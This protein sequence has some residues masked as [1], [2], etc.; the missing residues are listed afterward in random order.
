[1][2]KSEDF[3]YIVDYTHET[4]YDCESYGCDSICR[5]GQIENAHVVFV[6]VINITNHL[7]ELYFNNSKSSKRDRIINNVLG[8]ITDDINYYTIDRTLRINR[9]YDPDNWDINICRGYYGEEIESVKLIG[10]LSIKIENQLEEAFN[11]FD[12]SKRI[13]YLLKLEYGYLIDTLKG[14][15]YEIV[16]IDKNDITFGSDSQYRKV[17]SMDLPYYNKSYK[18]FRGVVIEKNDKYQL[19]DG[20]HRCLAVDGKFKVIKAI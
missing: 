5:C 15:K 16:I 7:Y 3:K 18:S 20:Y 11:I 13:E 10:S 17:K 19:V 12:L 8:D 4:V 2:I 1:M 14:K 6:N 9:I